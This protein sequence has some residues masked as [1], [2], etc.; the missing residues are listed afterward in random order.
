MFLLLAAEFLAIHIPARDSGN[1]VIREKGKEGKS[2]INL[3]NLGKFGPGP[4][5]Y[6]RPVGGPEN[7]LC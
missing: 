7:D 5:I 1:R 2:E 3:G 4:F 6:V